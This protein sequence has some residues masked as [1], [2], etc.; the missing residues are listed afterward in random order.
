MQQVSTIKLVRKILS[1]N[2]KDIAASTAVILFVKNHESLFRTIESQ[3]K[4][5][6][7]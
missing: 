7:P 1:C 3:F 4:N 5:M 2:S 6:S